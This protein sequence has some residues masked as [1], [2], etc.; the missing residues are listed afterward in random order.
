MA[1]EN[2]S[3]EVICDKCG[4]A[5]ASSANACWM[6]KGHMSAGSPFASPFKS[7]YNARAAWQINLA[8][9]MATITLLAVLL[10]VFRIAPG[11]GA[12]LTIVVLP[13]WI[14]TI[15][16]VGLQR[17][18]GRQMTTTERFALF[19]NSVGV[20]IAVVVIMLAVLVAALSVLCGVIIV[21]NPSRDAPTGMFVAFVVFVVA[22]TITA[23]GLL[24]VRAALRR[25]I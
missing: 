24:A 7:S 19:A 1:G 6:C 14:R 25:K 23:L 17:T 10:G 20:T 8:S 16:A 18:R 9:V 12:V 5:N 3:G 22:M 4:A 15:V 11:I 21:S 2:N 13:A